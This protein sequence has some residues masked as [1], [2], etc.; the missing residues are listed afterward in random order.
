MR[1]FVSLERPEMVCCQNDKKFFF[2]HPQRLPSYFGEM[3]R[4]GRQVNCSVSTP[5][6]EHQ[7]LFSHGANK[8]ITDL[9]VYF[10]CFLLTFIFTSPLGLYLYP[11]W[12]RVRGFRGVKAQEVMISKSSRMGSAVGKKPFNE[13]KCSISE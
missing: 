2:S 9:E 11:G 12:E 7:P 3:P 6:G 8:I 1:K 10:P 5:G 13:Y 4:Q